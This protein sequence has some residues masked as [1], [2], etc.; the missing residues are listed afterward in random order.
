MLQKLNER[1]QG[2]IAWIVIILIAITF[3]LF[4]IDYYIQSRHDTNTQVRVNNQVIS[5]HAFDVTYER[6]RQMYESRALS[7]I[8]DKKLKDR[9]LND[10]IMNTLSVQVA[11]K[12][13]FSIS[14]DQVHNAIKQIPQF[15][16]NG[17]FS[18]GRYQQVLTSA[19]FTPESFLAEVHQGMLVNQ[20][21]FAF[22]GTA[23]SLRRDI[24]QYVS[25]YAQT[26]DYDYLIIPSKPFLKEIAITDD[27]VQTYYKT[28]QTGYMSPE[29]VSID[30]IRLS[31]QAMRD[32]VSV[33]QADIAT[34]YEENKLNYHIPATW[35]VTRITLP[36][37]IKAT[38]EERLRLKNQLEE[39]HTKLTTSPD[40]F[41][42]LK[43]KIM[44]DLKT[45]TP[46]ETDG[47]IT[48][49]EDR[50][51]DALKELRVGNIS[52]V[53]ISPDS[54]ELLKVLEYTPGRT[55]PLKEVEA[56]IRTQLITEASQASYERALETLTDLSYQTP[57]S[58]SP[59]ANEL[60]LLVETTGPF[61]ANSGNG[62]IAENSD[63][64]RAAFSHD[65]LTLGN[66]SEPIQLDQDSVVVLRIRQHTPAKL[67]PLAS[68]ADQI[69]FK[70]A[71]DKAKEKATLLG[72]Q[73]LDAAQKG[74]T[75]LTKIMDENKLTWHRLNKIAREDSSVSS[76]VNNIAFSIGQSAQPEG[77]L[78]K[79]GG[80][81]LIIRLNKVNA[82]LISALDKE[83]IASIKQQIEASYGLMDYDLFINQQLRNA[84]IKH[85]T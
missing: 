77:H 68:V 32:K 19:L 4:G 62:S 16:E 60:N 56:Q 26:R 59:V 20:L 11:K 46:A 65:V 33:T 18:A 9:V 22:M 2:L 58:L 31:M 55:R 48:E 82:G 44:G 49:G 15:Q 84:K 61:T 54:F 5:K 51:S 42:L 34:H 7:A 57:D 72:S 37:S 13:G 73:V 53:I 47:L 76:E 66:N 79:T 39:V 6:T 64:R 69:K 14:T 28:H 45:A 10:M 25:L 30:Y 81:Y 52:D 24:Q 17:H 78:L 35:R 43:Q 83:Q 21:R 85:N 75:A 41:E 38:S 27:E 40:K 63:I 70:L 50:Y 67:K 36:V 74:D 71:R 29:E 80:G 3:S 1:I 8:D 12:N 23:F